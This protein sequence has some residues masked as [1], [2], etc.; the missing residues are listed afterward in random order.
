MISP[1]IKWNH[2]KDWY[3]PFEK[4][5]QIATQP[6]DSRLVVINYENEELRYLRDSIVGK[7]NVF[8]ESGYL[9]NTGVGNRLEQPGADIAETVIFRSKTDE[10]SMIS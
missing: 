5:D 7:K 2:E 8:P 10:Q 4:W 3:V 1:L 9:V 6:P